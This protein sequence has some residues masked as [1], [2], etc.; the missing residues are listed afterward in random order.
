[1]PAKKRKTGNSP[2][3]PRSSAKQRGEKKVSKLKTR[4]TVASKQ[5]DVLKDSERQLKIVL[6]AARMGIWEWDLGSNKVSW[7][8]DVVDIYKLTDFTPLNTFEG[9]MSIVHPDDRLW[10]KNLLEDCLTNDKEYAVEYRLLLNGGTVRWLATTGIVIRNQKK[11]PVKMTGTVQDITAKKLVE[12]EKEDWKTRH[13]LISMSAGLVIYDYDVST[14][15][16][17]WSG[18]SLEVLGYK[19]QELGNIDRWVELI[20]PDDRPEAFRLLEVAEKNLEPYDVYYRFSTKSGSY[21]HVHDRGFFVAGADGNASR[22]LGM[23]NDV[24]ERIK[25]EE[26][27]RDS[28]QRF[29][30]LQEAS[31]G[32]IGLHDQGKII[33][34]NQGLCDLTGFSYEE[35][36][37]KNGLDL[38]AP[39]YRDFVIDKIRSGYDKTYDV[40][41]I[42]KDGSRYFLEIRGKNIP[43]EGKS[44]RVTEFRDITERKRVEEK[45]VEQTTRLVAVTEDLKRKNNQ[46]EEFTQIVSHNLRSPVG[47]ILTLLSFYEGAESEGEK[48]EYISLL[49]EAAGT[50]LV[51]LNEL[52]DILK[53]KQTKNIEKQDL[54]FEKVMQQIRTMMYARITELGAEITTDFSKA[55]DICYPT[56]YL[57]SI[58][59]NLLDNALKYYSPDRPPRIEIATSTNAQGNIIL[60]IKDNGV[61]INLQ[62]YG[63]QVFKLRKTFHHHPESRGIGLFMIKNQIEAMGGE[64]TISSKENEGTSFFINFNKHQTDA[65]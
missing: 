60:E 29:R 58:L 15:D 38:I 32:G 25:A 3:K 16:I 57:E 4:P 40:E 34:C 26:S 51:M 6:S 20:H 18:N 48:T 1:M 55:P 17:I 45:I 47:N 2:S 30:T 49:K 23:M 13:E 59:L 56:I 12:K 52:N 42:R 7:Y 39:E 10:V 41:G 64:I 46:L 44:I 36:R 65:L 11:V 37:G 35:L 19:P 8:G 63:H 9:Y 14:G 24:T 31:F 53:I 5:L 27:L 50:T 28:E 62:R 33:D 22:M 54:K 43:F 21:V 61:G